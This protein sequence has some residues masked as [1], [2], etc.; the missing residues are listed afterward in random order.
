[1]DKDMLTTF[2]DDALD[3]VSGGTDPAAIHA[4]FVE[5]ITGSVEDYK[6]HLANRLETLS[7]L[8]QGISDG[9]KS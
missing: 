6:S 3:Q 4:A 1:M 9:I 7:G 5:Y 2:D 8:L